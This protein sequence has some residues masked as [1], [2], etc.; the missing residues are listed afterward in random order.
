MRRALN[1]AVDHL[2]LRV[3]RDGPEQRE[4]KTT[5]DIL[6]VL[7]RLAESHLQVNQ[8]TRQHQTDYERNQY[9]LDQRWSVGFS[10][11]IRLVNDLNIVLA[12]TRRLELL[13]ALKQRII[14][15][16]VRI[17]LSLKDSVAYSL[18]LLA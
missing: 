4:V 11:N 14:N 5:A 17:N 9:I 12:S 13:E 1:D 18:S 3:T 6:R 2:P 7:E 15:F 16:S 8:T 10:R